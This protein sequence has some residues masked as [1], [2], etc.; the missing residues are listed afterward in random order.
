MDYSAGWNEALEQLES[1]VKDIPADDV[2]PKSH[3]PRKE[4]VTV[5]NETD[6]QVEVE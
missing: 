4:T 3:E 5:I 2:R 1:D 6:K